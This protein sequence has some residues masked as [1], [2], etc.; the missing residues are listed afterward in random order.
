MIGD[1]DIFGTRVPFVF[2]PAYGSERI[3]GNFK[4]GDRCSSIGPTPLG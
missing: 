4:A 3:P 1:T 2:L